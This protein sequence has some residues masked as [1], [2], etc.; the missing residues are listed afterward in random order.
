MH[1]PYRLRWTRRAGRGRVVALAAKGCDR[2]AEQ[3]PVMVS[4]GRQ[5]RIQVGSRA[6]MAHGAACC[7]A[8]P[9]G[10]AIAARYAILPGTVQ[11]S[12]KPSG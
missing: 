5:R 3:A 10:A 4:L 11:Q 2:N 1:R 12:A 8:V 6:G 9:V 7:P